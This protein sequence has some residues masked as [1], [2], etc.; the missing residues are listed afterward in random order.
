VGKP[1]AVLVSVQLLPD[2]RSV[3]VARN[4]V[5]TTCASNGIANDVRDTAALLVSELVTNVVLHARTEIVMHI[6]PDEERLRVEVMDQDPAGQVL[7]LVPGP[8]ARSGRGVHMVSVLAAD[9]GI[10]TH[11]TG[12]TVWFELNIPEPSAER[13]G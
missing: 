11:A 12:K 9:W 10:T 4:F 8:T 6:R 13:A 3:A 7:L 5:T 1:L 2:A